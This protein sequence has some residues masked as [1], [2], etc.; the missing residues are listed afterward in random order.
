MPIENFDYDRGDGYDGPDKFALLTW[1]SIGF[2]AG[3]GVIGIPLSFYV[4]AQTED[5]NSKSSYC[6]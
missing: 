6:Q 5:L 3:W 1:I 2:A 4:R